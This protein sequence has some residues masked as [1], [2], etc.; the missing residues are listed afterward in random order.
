LSLILGAHRI[1]I[2]IDVLF[3][4]I[5]LGSTALIANALQTLDP[6]R[7]ATRFLLISAALGTWLYLIQIKLCLAIALFLAA[8]AA[9]RQAVRMVLLLL[10]VL[11][12]ETV[13]FLLLLHYLW[14]PSLDWRGSISVASAALLMGALLALIPE[15]SNVVGS[16]LERLSHYNELASTGEVGSISRTSFIAALMLTFAVA[17][18]L[19]NAFRRVSLKTAGWMSMPWLLLT[20][21]AFNEVLALRLAA[22]ALLHVLVVVPV[23]G[24][25]WHPWRFSLVSASAAIGLFAF[26]KDVLLFQ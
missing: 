7:P 21:L 13:L 6:D 18:W 22:L 19:L 25:R 14:R 1:G 23:L 4:C 24:G 10:A 15:V 3:A 26:Y 17:G 9:S 11:T 12:H 5:S 16:S 2:G 20:L 8:Q